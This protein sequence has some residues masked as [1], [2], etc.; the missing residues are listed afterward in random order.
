[1]NE[2]NNKIVNEDNNKIVNEDNDVND[3]DNNNESDND[4]D[5]DDY[6]D[7]DNDDRQYY[8]MRQLN[9]WFETTDKTKSL[10][11]QIELLREKGEFFSEYWSVHYYHDNKELNYKIFKAKAAYL[12]N[13]VD[14]EIFKKIFGHKFVTLADKLINA[15]SKEENQMLINDIK[16]NEDKIFEQDEFNKFVIQSS[17]KRGN[18]DDTVKVILEFNETIQSDL[19]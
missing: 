12:L 13:E 8:E 7:S 14:V 1:M 2:D 10:E 3:N 6:H 15:T 19:T 11:E 4:Y 17:Y 16:K 18:L 5:S 9:S